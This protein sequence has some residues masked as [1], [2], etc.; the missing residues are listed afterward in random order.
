MIYSTIHVKAYLTHSSH[1]KLCRWLL[2]NLLLSLPLLAAPG[3]AAAFGTGPFITTWK[4]DNPG[5]T[6]TTQIEIPTNGTGYDYSIYWEELN[7][8]ANN[9]SVGGL[10][11]NHI[12]DF[13][14]AGTYRVEISGDFPQIYFNNVGDKAKI[15]T[16]EQWGGIAWSSMDGAFFGC[17]NLTMPATDAPVLTLVTNMNSMFRDASKFNGDLSRWDVS[18]VTNMGNMFFGAAQFNGNISSWD[19][20]N[21]TNMGNMLRSTSF[22]QDISSW[23]VSNVVLMNQLFMNTTS[24]NQDISSWN[25][26]KVTNMAA[27]FNGASGFNQNLSSWNTSSVSLMHFM[28]QGATNFNGDISGWDVSSVTNMSFMFR[29]ASIFNKDISLWNTGNVTLMNRMFEGATSFNA[30][31]SNWNVSLVTDMSHMFSSAS[32]FNQNIGSWNVSNVSNM[33][34]MFNGA[35]NFNGDIGSWNVWKVKLMDY[36]FANSNFNQNIGGW[37]VSSVT[38]MAYMFNSASK[39]NGNIGSWDVGNV[40]DMRFMFRSASS[41]NQDI[42]FWNVSKVSK[43]DYMLSFSGMSTVNYDRLLK[44]WL[45]NGV[46]NGVTLHAGGR[47][48]C[49]GKNAR[50]TLIATHGWSISGDTEDC[51]HTI[52][53]NTL[54]Q[55]AY[56]D[57]AFE[58]NATS[59]LGLPVSYTSSDETVATVSGNVVTIIAPGSTTIT[60]SQPGTTD[61]VAATSVVQTL[62]VNKADQTISFA[63]LAAKTY[64]DAA[65][66]LTA[67]ANSGLPVSYTSSN[68]SVAT[69]SGSTVTI[70]G[71]GS[72]VI[73][74]SQAGDANYNAATPVEQTLVVNKKEQTIT[75]DALAAK[76][77]WDAAFELSAT[78]SS[79]LP[80]SY[81]SSNESVATVSGSTVTIVGPGSTTITASQP[82]NEDYQSATPVDQVL[83][84][85]KASQSITFNAFEPKVIG[86]AAFELTA[87]ASS[88]LPVS[89]TSSDETVATVNGSTLTI[90][91]VGSAIITASQAGNDQYNAATPVEQTL[92]VNKLDQSVTFGTLAPKAVGDAAFDLSATASSGLAVSYTSSDE[93]VAIVSGS[94]VTIVGAGS[95]TITASQAGNDQYNAAASVEQILT[96]GKIQQTISMEPIE[97]KLADAGQFAVVASA[98]SGLE[99]SFVVSGPATISGNTITLNGTAG[100]VT[101]TASQP[102]NETYLTAEPVVQS[103]KVTAVTGIA[104]LE[105]AGIRIFPNPAADFL[106]VEIEKNNNVQLSLFDS[107]GK[108]LLELGRS[109]QRVDISL[110]KSGVYFLR[111]TSPGKNIYHKFLKQ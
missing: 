5:S 12:I 4:T 87:T 16:I 62:T 108:I 22:N 9:G 67:T 29:F 13:P 25:V 55:K 89:Y 94:T 100:T 7:N 75:F 58:L 37:N 2:L 92:T 52:T 35:T 63:A 33:E 36:M 47:K 68:T 50:A 26:S 15:L 86:S 51:T 42:S 90:V 98:S 72:A 76:T 109:S 43:M 70:V 79:G 99:V 41:F 38:N 111:I 53:F 74:A 101:V 39:F 88:G 71:A 97:D 107:N 21:V 80:V 84:V 8:A 34:Y 48:Y 61:Y 11:G 66:E 82:G 64:G 24:F 65:F 18:S 105:K 30:D 60:A 49:I 73:T 93:T 23:N 45:A 20:S 32:N 40:T 95:T 106:Q 104:E 56:G 59:S 57:P 83:S 78:A 44:S 17:I 1:S 14:S 102:G 27:M 31:I 96:V 3:I 77:V 85:G 103:F 6:T 46:Q 28:F 54:A 81:T 10:T 110:L 91:G 19:V 69:V